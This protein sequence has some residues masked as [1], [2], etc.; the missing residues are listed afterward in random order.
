MSPR[1]AAAPT[2][3]ETVAVVGP[4]ASGKSALADELAVR[5]GSE[6]VSADAMQVYRRM[7]IGTAKTPPGERRAPL[8][9][10]DLVDPDEPYSVALYAQEAHRAI[11]E[12]C[13]RGLV[14]VVCGGT[15]LYVRAALEDMDFP[16]GDQ[17]GN[18]VRD[19]YT[20]LA[21]DIGADALH[22]RLEEID[23]ESAALIHPHNVRR[24]VRAFEL[25]EGGSSYAREHETLHVRRDRRRTL[26][27]GLSV[28]RHVLYG[29]IDARVDAMLEQGLLD[30]VAR[31]V[32]DG[33]G[34]ALTSRQAIG[35]KEFIDVL[36]GLRP[37]EDAVE[38]V[39]R[40][41]RRY[42]KRQMTWFRADARI[43]WL[44]AEDADPARLA[45]QV[46]AMLVFGDRTAGP[47]RV[48]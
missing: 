34:D 1:G 39:K 3:Y 24:V 25:L 4:T 22:R 12:V 41:T 21:D 18:P 35:Y 16:A 11:D 19:R 2:R 44:D 27:V 23:P 9:C 43:A 20:K 29:R 47:K 6:V 36:R 17:V 28:P 26:H 5:L 48:G 40:S 31:L 8:R 42:A 37:L 38:E 45:D 32:D 7:D 15:G 10:V 46:E 30:E 13:G 33:L 14:P